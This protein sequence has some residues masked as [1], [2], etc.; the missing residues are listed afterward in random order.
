MKCNDVRIFFSRIADKSGPTAISS[1]D[2]DFLRDNGYLNVMQM[3]DYNRGMAEVSTLT[4]LNIDLM[5]ER[6]AEN[7]ERA[8]LNEDERKS[9]SIAFLFE[10]KENK[11]VQKEDIESHKEAVSK[12]DADIAQRETQVNELIKKKSIFDRMVP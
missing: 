11:E 7:S 12:M 8:H 5:N 3:D 1:V 2:M 10:G 6:I 4:Q 9:H